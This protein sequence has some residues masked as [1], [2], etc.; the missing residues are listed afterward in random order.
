[1]SSQGRTAGSTALSDADRWDGPE[2]SKGSVMGARSLN[3]DCHALAIRWVRFRLF[4]LRGET[5]AAFRFVLAAPDTH[6]DFRPCRL[7]HPRQPPQ[8]ARPSCGVRMTPIL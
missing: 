6:P 4:G 3:R 2:G 8:R 5:K 1:M 7:A